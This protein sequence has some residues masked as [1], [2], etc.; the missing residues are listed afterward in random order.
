MTMRVDV[1]E[2][3]KREAIAAVFGD[4]ANSGR[5]SHVAASKKEAT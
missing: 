2:S 1:G 4:I 5:G 3:D